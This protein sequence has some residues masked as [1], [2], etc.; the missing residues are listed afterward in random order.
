[1]TR[2]KSIIKEGG[3]RE[4]DGEVE[5]KLNKITVVVGGMR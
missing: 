1:M 5:K 2:S 3:E 4:G